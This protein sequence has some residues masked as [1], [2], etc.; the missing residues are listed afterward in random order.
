MSIDAT[1]FSNSWFE[2]VHAAD[3]PYLV[4]KNVIAGQV[5]Q[6]ESGWYLTTGSNQTDSSVVTNAQ[7]RLY[8]G[9][10][11]LSVGTTAAGSTYQLRLESTSAITL[12]TATVIG[13]NFADLTVVGTLQA[14]LYA[15][16]G[17]TTT[18]IGDTINVTGDR[19]TWTHLYDAAGK[20]SYP[21]T[22]TITP[23]STIARVYV[24]LTN[25]NP[26]SAIKPSAGEFWIGSRQALKHAP[27]L[28]YDDK[29]E[30]GLVSDFQAQS[31]LTERYVRHR[32][33]AS[34]IIAKSITDSTEL[35]QIETAFDNSEDFTK[36]VLWVEDP[37]S[38]PTAYIML[39][40]SPTLSVPLQGPVER[41]FGVN[42]DE[43]PPY[44]SSEG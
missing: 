31:G 25:V 42:L 9:F 11:N 30:S 35:T 17:T 36:P 14:T 16:D 21:E 12:D 15:Y 32:G 4:G 3:K 44:R 2:D 40:E 5:N 38:D 39:P 10:G 43:L 13:H 8:D 6:S 29:A 37:S 41:V 33:R 28:P 7:R 24:S 34:R 20:Q 23:V 22:V 1:R 27:N 19:L 26:G 18:Q